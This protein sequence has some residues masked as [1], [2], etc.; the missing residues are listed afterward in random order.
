MPE[1]W[2]DQLRNITLPPETVAEAVDRLMI[3]LDNEHKLVIATRTEEELIDLH[4][5]LGAAIRNAFWLHDRNS[6][7]LADCGVMHPDDAA[8]VIVKE[9]WKKL[10]ME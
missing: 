5:S 6:K 2:P 9:I 7:L 4:F 8:G 1:N 3:V 10:T